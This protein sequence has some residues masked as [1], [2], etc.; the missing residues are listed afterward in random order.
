[1]QSISSDVKSTDGE[2][3][4]GA[5]DTRPDADAPGDTRP[6]PRRR[7]RSPRRAAQARQ[8]RMAIL[9]AAHDLFVERGYGTTTIADIAAAASVAPETV[10]SAFRNKPTLLKTLADV[11]AAGDDEP[12]PVAQREPFLRI[13]EEP[14]VH[15]KLRLY[16]AAA[17]GM[18]ERGV[19]E[20]QLVVRAAAA[21]DPKIAKLWSEL[22][23]QRLVGAARMAEHLAGARLLRADLSVERA[24]DLIW[25]AIAPEIDGLLVERG[26]TIDERERWLADTLH[27]ALVAD[28]PG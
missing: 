2:R 25:V 22:K 12:V 28:P 20:V 15:R 13:L 1:M 14:D 9:D 17:R 8:T 3:A 16:A 18:L 6:A 11:R 19:G 23:R 21:A 4:A 10:Y 5:G 24:R 26:W 7:Y 27:A